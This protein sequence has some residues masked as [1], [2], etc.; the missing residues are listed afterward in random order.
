MAQISEQP[1]YPDLRQ[2]IQQYREQLTDKPNNVRLMTN[3]AWSYERS[4]SFS[5]AIDTFTKALKIDPDYADAQ[6]GL[7]L[8]LIQSG[9]TASALEAFTRVR[10][11]IGRSKDRA[12][13]AIVQHHIDVFFRRYGTA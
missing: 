9:Q 12:Y 3:L 4:R 13:A 11:L 5:E 1:D 7:G 10:S 8:A 6:Y 2:A